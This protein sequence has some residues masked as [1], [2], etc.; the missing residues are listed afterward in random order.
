MGSRPLVACPISPDRPPC[1][2]AVADFSGDGTAR[3]ET[4]EV[5]GPPAAQT[6]PCPLAS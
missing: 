5:A 4:T 1:L 3:P 6:K 2:A